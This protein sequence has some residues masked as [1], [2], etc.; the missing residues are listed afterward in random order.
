MQSL[1]NMV[2]AQDEE[3]LKL[4]LGLRPAPAG[5]ADAS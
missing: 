5:D 1:F 3:P 4:N 2:L